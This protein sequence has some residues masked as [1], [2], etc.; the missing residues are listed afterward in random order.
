MTASQKVASVLIFLLNRDKTFV[1]GVTADTFYTH[2][3]T[4]QYTITESLTE[5]KVRV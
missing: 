2:Y 4:F 1:S 5:V 3:L